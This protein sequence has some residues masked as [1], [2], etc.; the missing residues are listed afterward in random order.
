MTRIGLR[1]AFRLRR[2]ATRLPR[3]GAG[4]STW[5]SASGNP[6]SRSRAATASAARVV[7]PDCVVSIS[8]SSSRIAFARR[9]CSSGPRC[10]RA[11]ACASSARRANAASIA[12]KTAL[13]MAAHAASCEPPPTYSRPTTN[14]QRLTTHDQRAG[15]SCPRGP[16]E[17]TEVA[18]TAIGPAKLG[19]ITTGPVL[20][21]LPEPASIA[22]GHP[23]TPT[24]SIALLLTLSVGAAA[25]QAET[26]RFA[27]RAFV[28][29]FSGAHAPVLRIKSGDR[30]VTAT[31]NRHGG[32]AAA[33]SMAAAPPPQ[34]GPFFV[35][36]A[37]PGDLLVVTIERL[38]PEPA[39]R[40]FHVE[41]VLERGA[42]GGARRGGPTPTATPGSS[43]TDAAWSDSISR[44]RCQT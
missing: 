36:G 17:A 39:G 44:R 26:H 19:V 7:L 34:T 27:P 37:E 13:G 24:S 16:A 4:P 15:R 5:M 41:P 33:A 1:T 25:L 28:T 40:L 23:M 30:V 8:T 12:A 6:A 22:P 3:F 29:T 21:P 43:T 35:E 10:P 11:G 18:V 14:D 42:G 9:S 2:R 31:A 20:A 38:V 32:D